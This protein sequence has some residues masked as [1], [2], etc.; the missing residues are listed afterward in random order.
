MTINRGP[1][2]PGPGPVNVARSPGALLKTL[3]GPAVTIT[4]GFWAERQAINR[5]SGLAHG[6]RMLE[7]AGN[8]DNLRIAAGRKT[9]A[10]RGRV[11]MDSDV[12]KWL[13]AAAWEMA[14]EPSAELRSNC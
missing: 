9:G 13:E 14:R 12:Y 11:F 4:G 7:T 5:S 6:L 2:T 1:G 8:L 3:A 10:F